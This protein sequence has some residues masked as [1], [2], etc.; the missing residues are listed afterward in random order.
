MKK[1]EIETLRGEHHLGSVQVSK[2]GFNELCDLALRGLE[3]ESADQPNR[4]S[5]HGMYDCNLFHKI[6]GRTVDEVVNLWLAHNEVPHPATIEGEH[7]ANLGPSF[8]CPAI[9]LRGNTELR[10]VGNMVHSSNDLAAIAAY[11]EALKRDPD[12]PRLLAALPKE[13]E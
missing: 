11:R 12:I 7:C 1:E 8:L 10:R 9:V 4:V 3:R 5:I 2:V 6:I 13:G